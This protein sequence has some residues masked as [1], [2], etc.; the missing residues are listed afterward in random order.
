MKDNKARIDLAEYK[1]RSAW[2]SI[3][4]MYH[5]EAKKYGVT[6]A[7]GFAL[8]SIHPKNGTPSTSIGPIMGMEA[9]SLSRILKMMEEKKLI[10]KKTNPNDGRGVLIFLT[11]DGLSKREL[12]KKKIIKF[13]K[14]VN[15]NITKKN[16]DIFFK[17]A[18]TI[19][20]LASEKNILN[21]E[22]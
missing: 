16:M 4:K 22:K 20:K 3:K 14:L 8:L 5:E 11:K 9:N 13:N 19:K 12:T 6:H 1:L 18:E 7:I 21:N 15:T 2:Y 10:L 17:T